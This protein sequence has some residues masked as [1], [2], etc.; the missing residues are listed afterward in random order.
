M[1]RSLPIHPP[2]GPTGHPNSPGALPASVVRARL[3]VEAVFRSAEW[4]VA[5]GAD[6]LLLLRHPYGPTLRFAATEADQVALRIHFDFCDPAEEV[7][8]ALLLEQAPAQTFPLG[9]IQTG[10]G[11]IVVHSQRM[12]AHDFDLVELMTWFGD[13]H[14][15]LTKNASPLLDGETGSGPWNAPLP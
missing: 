15:F 14:R 1:H 8:F 4:P 6:S 12:L 7:D 2:K 13:F 10:G 11:R 9:F 5:I 3:R